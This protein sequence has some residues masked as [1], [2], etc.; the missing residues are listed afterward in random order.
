MSLSPTYRMMT[1][2]V[3]ATLRLYRAD[4][5]VGVEHEMM[6]RQ[7]PAAW[8]VEAFPDLMERIAAEARNYFDGYV[9]SHS[10]MCTGVYAYFAPPQ[11]ITNT[12]A[13]GIERVKRI[14]K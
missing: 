9:I 14:T 3:T 11:S 5:P 12:E 4:I 8:F 7:R 10:Q 2:F 6:L 1:Y 13:A